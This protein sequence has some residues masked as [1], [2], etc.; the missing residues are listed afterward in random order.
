L[1]ELLKVEYADA[2]GYVRIL[3]G[4]GLAR[5]AGKEPKAAGVRGKGSTLWALPWSVTIEIPKEVVAIAA[6]PPELPDD[7]MGDDS[8]LPQSPSG[9]KTTISE[10]NNGELAAQNRVESNSQASF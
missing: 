8:N 5:E 3:V 1:S 10:D 7:L 9:V 4:M 6:A 2:A